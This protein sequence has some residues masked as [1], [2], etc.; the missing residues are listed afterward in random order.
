MSREGPTSGGVGPLRKGNASRNTGFKR[1]VRAAI[2]AHNEAGMFG[3]STSY[4]RS[5]NSRATGRVV[6][7][8]EE[9]TSELQ[10]R[11]H[12]VCR[13]LLEKKE[14][15]DEACIQFVVNDETTD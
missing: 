12:L 4:M 7:R 10:S 6:V 1:L 9:H 5:S 13:L 15:A 3:S 2:L 11:G 14:A 8:S